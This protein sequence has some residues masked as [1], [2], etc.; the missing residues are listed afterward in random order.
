MLEKL[1]DLSG[2]VK[3]LPVHLK[4][5]YPGLRQDLED[6]GVFLRMLD[7]RVNVPEVFRVGYG[8]GRKGGV[9]PLRTQEK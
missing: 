4:E 5:G 6:L 1:Q 8:L 3:L 7:G 9:K 2:E